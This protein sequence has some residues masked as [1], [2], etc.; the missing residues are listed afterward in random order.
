MKNIRIIFKREYLSRIKNK[1]FI[2]LTLITP[3][4]F[5]AFYAAV[6]FIAVQSGKS[7]EYTQVNYLDEHNILSEAV[8]KDTLSNFIF[9]KVDHPTEMKELLDNEYLALLHIKDK[10][11]LSIDSLE[12]I[13]SQ[14]PSITKISSLQSYLTDDIF[15]QSLG[16]LNITNKQLDELKPRVKF[17]TLEAKL[18]GDLKSSNSGL[19]SGIGMFMAFII[20][21]FIFIYGSMV[22]RSTIEEKTNRIVEVIVSSVKPFDLMLGKILGVAAV[23]LTQFIAWIVLGTG[24]IT[25]ISLVLGLSAGDSSFYQEIAAGG[26]N[27]AIA[28]DTVSSL[29]QSVESLPFAKI[30]TVFLLFFVGGYLLYSSLFAAIGS[31]VNQDSDTQQFMFPVSLP[32]VFGFIIAQ[33]AVFQDPNGAIAKVFSYIPF[34]SPVV[35]SAR[36]AFGISWL[37]I[38]TSFFIL[39]A[40]FLFMVWLSARIYRVGILMYG[41]KPKWKDFAKWIIRKN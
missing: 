25:V 29:I 12:F 26:E 39:I 31:A 21:I 17:K 27:T 24:L 4:I 10:D 28:N 8:N 41:K 40:T 36:V 22:M 3:L 35:M 6:A 30:I 33:S 9:H 5:V 32:L 18:D 34:T 1:S 15:T 20:Y 2:L 37:E 19:K 7:D 14:T 16:E 38:F 11:R 23:G 13:S